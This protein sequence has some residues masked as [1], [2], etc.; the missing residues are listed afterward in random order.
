MPQNE[1][2]NI[3]PAISSPTISQPHLVEPMAPSTVLAPGQQQREPISINEARPGTIIP[4]APANAQENPNRKPGLVAQRVQEFQKRG[5]DNGVPQSAQQ[6]HHHK[7]N[8]GLHAAISS[9]TVPMPSGQPVSVGTPASSN[10]SLHNGQQNDEHTSSKD[11]KNDR[12]VDASCPDSQSK[13]N[14]GYRDG[15]DVNG[16]RSFWHHRIGGEIKATER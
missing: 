5:T 14:R 4:A 9:P 11:P 12:L 10:Q 2:P 1:V 13:G 8:A 6:P 16:A 7:T 3:L 15:T